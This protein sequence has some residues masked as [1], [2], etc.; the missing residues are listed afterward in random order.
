MA[1]YG[2]IEEFDPAQENWPQYVERLQFFLIANWVE[3][4]ERKHARLPTV[5]G[6]ATYSILRSLAYH[7][8]SYKDLIAALMT[9]FNLTPSFIV[10]HF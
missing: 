7:E 2:K 1:T 4:N 9:H 3:S 8:K 6:A 10:Q 5:V